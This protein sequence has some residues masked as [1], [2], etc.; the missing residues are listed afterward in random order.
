MQLRN[1][2]R[3]EQYFDM[4]ELLRE[5]GY[6]DS[7]RKIY[8]P[9]HH[10]TDD[11][12]A[13]YYENT[14]NIHCFSEHRHYGPYDLL[15]LEG[16]SDEEISEQ[17]PDDVSFDPETEYEIEIDQDKLDEL[18]SQWKFGGQQL[19]KVLIDFIINV[20]DRPD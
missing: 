12:A 13:Y 5:F 14:N 10:N 3:V 6:M 18:R 20:A 8:C 7:S 4:G 9:F 15:K 17:V 2:K 11:K 1:I 19:S 16:Y